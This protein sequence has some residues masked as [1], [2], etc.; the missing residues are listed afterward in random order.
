MAET[1]DEFDAPSPCVKGY[2]NR[3]SV[4]E[5]EQQAAETTEN[6]LQKLLTFLESNPRNYYNVFRKKK[7]DQ[8]NLL[9]FVKV[10]VM[11]TLKGEDYLQA[12]IP[13]EECK[14]NMEKLQEQMIS[15]FDYAQGTV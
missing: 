7:F 9:S 5:F 8:M 2:C 12:H 3:I 15:A 6:E 14:E 10:K 1:L 11:S 13:N 4:A